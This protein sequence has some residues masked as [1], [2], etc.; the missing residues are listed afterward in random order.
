MDDD[1]I[2]E[3]RPSS[4]RGNTNCSAGRKRLKRLVTNQCLGRARFP[5][6]RSVQIFIGS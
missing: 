5:R 1:C 3:R 2:E 4:I 6:Q